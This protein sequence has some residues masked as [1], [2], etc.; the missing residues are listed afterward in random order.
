M[1]SICVVCGGEF[2]KQLLSRMRCVCSS[3]RC[4]SGLRARMCVTKQRAA[5]FGL[6]HCQWLSRPAMPVNIHV[7]WC[8]ADNARQVELVVLLFVADGGHYSCSWATG[9]QTGC[10]VCSVGAVLG[11][12][13]CSC[14]MFRLTVLHAF[15]DTG[16]LRS[17]EALL[18][19]SHR[20]LS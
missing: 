11:V 16:V 3:T 20:S 19:W 18:C 2:V 4:E 12:V 17:G 9:S 5:K 14:G 10:L 7:W 8:W 1:N 6:R 13:C 15:A